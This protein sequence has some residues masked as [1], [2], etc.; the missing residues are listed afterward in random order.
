MKIRFENVNF[1]SN[2]GPNNFASKLSHELIK[3]GH[4]I[5][6]QSPDVQLS[7]IEILEKYKKNVL[8][9]DGI[10]FNTDQDWKKQN[11]N[12]AYSYDIS[13]GVVVQSYFDLKL[14]TTFFGSRDNVK[15]IHNG[16]CLDVINQIDKAEVSF[17]KSVGKVWFT[18]SSWRPHK[19]LNENIRLFHEMSDKDDILLVAGNN[20]DQSINTDRISY[21]GNLQW[22]NLISV[23]KLADNFIH[24]AW[25]DHCPNVVVDAKAAGCKLYCT[26]AGGTHELASEGDVVIIEEEW[27][28][29]PCKLYK[30]PKLSFSNYSIG[31][32]RGDYGMK[33]CHG[34]YLDF[35][36]EIING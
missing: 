25:L 2:S 4:N 14:I 13:D 24:T 1:S 26:N 20:C 28:F 19:R 22:N 11:K 16:T 29:K 10:Y 12:I 33:V 34:K 8:R 31:D 7:F 18:A 17:N 9:L 30:P 15:V 27:D 32:Y 35:F 21:I 3:N 6:L 5:E 23:M 36:S